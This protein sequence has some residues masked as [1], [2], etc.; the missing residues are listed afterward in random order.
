MRAHLPQWTLQ[1]TRG[2]WAE[3]C[4]TTQHLLRGEWA[5]GGLTPPTHPHPRTPPLLSD[6]AKFLRVFGQSKIF[7]G[8]F[9]ASQFR[10]KISSVPS[11]SLTTQGL[12]RGGVP[13]TAPPPPLRK[14]LGRGHDCEL[15]AADHPLEGIG[16]GRRDDRECCTRAARRPSPGILGVPGTFA[17]PHRTTTA[18]PGPCGLRRWRGAAVA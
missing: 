18:G 7:S 13:P 15:L 2:A 14:T 8:S 12:L 3:F 17:P 11:A 6:W 4:L 10:P 16:G 9:G 5:G 1:R